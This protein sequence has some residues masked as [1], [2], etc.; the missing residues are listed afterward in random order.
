MKCAILI[1]LYNAEETLDETFKSLKRQTFQDFRIIAINDHS[2]D[3]TLSLIRKWQEKMGK[4]RFIIINNDEN[5]GL[6]KSLNN[7]LSQITEPYTARI[8]ADD[9]WD[10]T[11]LEKQIAYLEKY[12]K[13]SII[14]T[15]YINVSSRGDQKVMLPVTD[16]DVKKSIFKRNPFAHSCVIFRTE[17]I[18]EAGCYD[19]SIRFGQ[20]YEL[21]LRLLPKTNFANIPE[22]LCFR[23]IEDTLTSSGKNQSIQMLQCVKTQKKY[24]KLYNLPFL[25]YRFIIEPFLVAIAPQWLRTFKRKFF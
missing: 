4:D 11:K 10:T 6:T 25:E 12:P 17:L 16:T 8:D 2:T 23:N 14:G 3:Q 5:I 21:W 15:W 7:G 24:L 19:E 22:F 13:C 1:S 20:D 18:K 9:T